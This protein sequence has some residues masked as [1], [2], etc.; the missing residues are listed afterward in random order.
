M[1]TFGTLLDGTMVIVLSTEL[2]QP[3]L[4]TEVKPTL[5]EP[6]ALYLWLGLFSLLVEPSPNFQVF[7]SDVDVVII[8]LYASPVDIA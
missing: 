7:L 4:S 5:Y 3:L 1:N 8:F 2:V 6:G